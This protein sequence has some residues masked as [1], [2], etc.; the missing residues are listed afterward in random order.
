MTA[1]R[2][3][4]LVNFPIDG[5]DI[6]DAALVVH[7]ACRGLVLLAS[8]HVVTLIRW[9]GTRM[10]HGRRETE[11]RARCCRPGGTPFS[12]PAAEVLAI[13]LEVDAE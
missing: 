7:A 12:V 2:P 4:E 10:R 6:D 3:R 13:C 5:V 1:T 8:G 9:K 11:H